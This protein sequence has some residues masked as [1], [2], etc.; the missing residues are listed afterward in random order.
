MKGYESSESENIG[1]FVLIE[2]RAA[3]RGVDSK[4]LVLSLSLSKTKQINKFR[5]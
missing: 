3:N 4:S 2:K 5:C 1:I